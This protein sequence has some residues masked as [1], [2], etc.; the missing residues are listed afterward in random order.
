[1]FNSDI[2]LWPHLTRQVTPMAPPTGC[3]FDLYLTGTIQGLRDFKLVYKGIYIY[4]YTLLVHTRKLAD[5][6]LFWILECSNFNS[7]F[8]EKEYKVLP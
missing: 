1:M 2:T 5:L 6:E 3:T 4:I 8:L 7:N